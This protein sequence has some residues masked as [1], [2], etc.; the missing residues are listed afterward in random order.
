MMKMFPENKEEGFLYE[1]DADFEEEFDVDR[2]LYLNTI[3]SMIR[4]SVDNREEVK[5]EDFAARAGLLMGAHRLK[6]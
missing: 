2:D 5:F 4:D 1:D 3:D 6:N